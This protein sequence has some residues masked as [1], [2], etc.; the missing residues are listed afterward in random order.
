MDSLEFLVSRESAFP[1]DELGKYGI[2]HLGSLTPVELFF[3]LNLAITLAILF[4]VLIGSAY[5][6]G[7]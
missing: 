6:A 4:L 5:S 2:E 1:E 3:F 7:M